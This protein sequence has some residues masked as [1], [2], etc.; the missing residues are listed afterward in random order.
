MQVKM[1]AIEIEICNP[2]PSIYIAVMGYIYGA[3]LASSLIVLGIS[4]NN[5]KGQAVVCAGNYN[6]FEK[7]I[8]DILFIRNNC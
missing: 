8:L 5:E 6:I 4:Q 1:T 2:Y 7:I 3:M